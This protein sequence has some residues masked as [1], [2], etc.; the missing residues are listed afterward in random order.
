[1]PTIPTTASSSL[2]EDM[3]VLRKMVRYWRKDKSLLALAMVSGSVRFT[4][5]HYNYVKDI[6]NLD[7]IGTRDTSDS[8][9][10]QS[11]DDYDC[12]IFFPHD[13]GTGS[14]EET[15]ISRI[16]SYK[17]IT[18][19]GSDVIKYCLPKSLL[20]SV[21]MKETSD[22]RDT[23]RARSKTQFLDH[24]QQCDNEKRSG[25][26][27]GEDIAPMNP[28]GHAEITSSDHTSGSDVRVRVV[29]PSSWANYDV[30][31]LIL[32]NIMY[33]SDLLDLDERDFSSQSNSRDDQEL[34]VPIIDSSTL[35]SNRASVLE[36]NTCIFIENEYIQD[37][38]RAGSV[39]ELHINDNLV[40]YFIMFCLR[41]QWRLLH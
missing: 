15:V 21:R 35:V 25:N 33:G 8:L 36:S 2:E 24:V 23:Q 17:S 30:I 10:I 14:K 34:P 19:L 38:A 16:P 5:D 29:V 3:N 11:D 20:I 13:S 6:I 1:M 9:S 7:L 22:N 28:F 32:F 27:S 12:N 37:Y 18:R 40:P 4:V 31:N 41:S 26:S 39:L